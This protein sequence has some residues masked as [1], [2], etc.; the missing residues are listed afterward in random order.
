ML[1]APDEAGPGQVRA[2]TFDTWPEE[3]SW[4]AD[5]IAAAKGVGTVG[6]WADI[7]V[8]VRR[9][10]DIAPIYS[11]LSARDIPVEIVG[12]GGLLRLPEIMDVTATLR[13]I[14]DVTANAALLRLLTGP[15]WRIGPRDLAL[16]GSRARELSRRPGGT[17][18]TRRRLPRGEHG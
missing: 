5:Q 2:A 15:R 9:N 10:A 8:L 16:L 6:H 17:R 1:R 18:P 7:A 14:S 12:L 13:L 4:I 3:V 11:E